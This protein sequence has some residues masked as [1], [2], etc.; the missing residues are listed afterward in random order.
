[1]IEDDNNTFNKNVEETHSEH[2]SSVDWEGFRHER[3]PILKRFS[4]FFS[5]KINTNS[6]YHAV[7]CMLQQGVDEYH[8]IEEL[9]Q[10]NEK[11]SNDMDK[12][13]EHFLTP[14]YF[15]DGRK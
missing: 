15:A 3:D 11:L 14:K 1:M 4:I 2:K 10:K 6:T 7:Y 8:I 12:I 13:Q 9:L 5:K